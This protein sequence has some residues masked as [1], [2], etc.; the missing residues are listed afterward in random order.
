[1]ASPLFLSYSWSDDTEA[2]RLDALLRFRGVPIWRDRRAMQWGGFHQDQVRAAIAEL[3]SGFSIYLTPAALDQNGSRFITEVELPAMDDRRNRDANFFSGAIFAGYSAAEGSNAAQEICGFSVGATFGS[4]IDSGHDLD[5]QLR[6]AALAILR[7][8]LASLEGSDSLSVFFD[9]RQEV[10]WQEPADIHLSWHPPLEHGLDNVDSRVWDEN[11]VP[12]LCDLNNALRAERAPSHLVVKGQPHL[13][14]ALALGHTFRAP[15]PWS[16]ELVGYGGS[17][18]LSGPREPD[19]CGWTFEKRAGQTGPGHDALVVRI[20]ATHEIASAV[21]AARRSLPGPR[22]TLDLHPPSDPSHTS[23]EPETANGLAAAAAAAIA[24][25]RAE[26][27]A[28]ETHLYMACPWPFAALLGH[29]LA[30]AGPMVS[31]EANLARDNYLRAC[32]LA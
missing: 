16:L 5:P 14:A 21:R 15:G 13:S 22:A 18:W 25:A 29:H 24:A 6:S 30:S 9:T 32:R 19:D 23:I 7:R 26:Y 8:Y 1:M 10:P 12:A 31:F 2:D 20:H 11:L 4:S 3:C 17:R 28:A 27:G